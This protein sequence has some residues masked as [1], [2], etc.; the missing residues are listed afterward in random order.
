[1]QM[2]VKLTNNHLST[3]ILRSDNSTY[4]TQIQLSTD[5]LQFLDFDDCNNK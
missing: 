1:M 2:I 4:V 5:L 3:I